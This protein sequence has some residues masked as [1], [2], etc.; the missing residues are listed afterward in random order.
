MAATDIFPVDPDYTVTRTKEA[1]V[2]RGRVE[3]AREFLRQKAAPRR[4]FV[5]VFHSRAKADWDAIE[6]FRLRMLTDFFTFDDKSAGGSPNRQYSVYFDTEPVYEEVGNETHNIR[7]QLIE[8][9]GVAMNTYPSFAAGNPSVNIPVAQA[10][11]LGADG[12]QFLYPGYGYRVNGTF[13]QIYLDE[14]LTGGE[15]P[16]TDVVLGLHRVRVVGGTPTSL[17]YLI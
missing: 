14:I 16:K 1:N 2:L 11:D 15:N 17:D 7:V 9:A 5:L 8:A 12:K 10:T 6:N 4:V 13:T 3:S